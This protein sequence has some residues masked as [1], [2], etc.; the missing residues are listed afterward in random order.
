VLAPTLSLLLSWP[1]LG[2]TQ[3]AAEAQ[4][5]HPRARFSGVWRMEQS[6]RE[7]R[8][9]VD[10]AIERAVGAM[11]F[12]FRGIARSRLREGTPI[13]DRI[14]LE[15]HEDDRVTVRFDGTEDYTTRI[16]RTETRRGPDG[17]Q[18]RI[19]QRFRSNGQLVQ[20]FETDQG[21]RWYV[22][23]PLR[24]GRLRLATTTDSPRMPQPMMFLLDYER[25]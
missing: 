8:S 14:D 16:G 2:H 13:H 19:T 5:S 23:T 21:T 12:F 11:N 18:M 10:E 24:D 17:T 20:S 6:P 3:A 1:A 9:L 7:A 25:E 4:H 22:Y 15:V